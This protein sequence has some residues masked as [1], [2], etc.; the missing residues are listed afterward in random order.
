M[1]LLLKRLELIKNAIAIEDEEIVELQLLKLKQIDTSDEIF[2]IVTMLEHKNY[3]EA[4]LK[5]ESYLSNYSSLVVYED[6]QLQGLKFELSAL[7]NSFEELSAKKDEYLKEVD[8]FNFEYHRVLGDIIQ[9]ILQIKEQ[10][11]FKEVEKKRKTF[12]E[13]KEQY[14]EI[15]EEVNTLKKEKEKI[16]KE[17]EDIDE[18]EDDYDKKYEELNELKEKLNKKEQELN[19]KRK[20]A[21]K[22]K[23]EYKQD[24]KNQ[25]YEDVKKDYEEFKKEYRNVKKEQRATLSQEQKKELKKL[26]RQASKLCHPDIVADEFKEQAQ[27]IFQELNNANSKNDIETVRKIYESLKSFETFEV[28]SNSLEDKTLLK[29][30]I[31]IL[32]EKIN[33]IEKEIEEIQKNEVFLILQEYENIDKYL[34][35]IKEELEIELNALKE[36]LKQVM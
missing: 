14:T 22:A 4:M 18:F 11:L 2:S 12:E 25:E 13:K 34:Q 23:D 1:K 36:T 21:K 6:A 32:K 17:L 31:S 3:A 5:I 33:K 26:Y 35:W 10:I 20:E 27:I 28:S 7:E 29:Q 16:E 15:K 30:K 19:E 9:N 8:Q 24:E